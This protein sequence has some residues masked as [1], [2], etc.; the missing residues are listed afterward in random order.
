MSARPK[1]ALLWHPRHWR[2]M[3]KKYL[4]WQHV[5]LWERD[6]MDIGHFRSA[7]RAAAWADLVIV[8][9]DVSVIHPKYIDALANH[10]CV[11]N[12]GVLD[13]RKSSTSECTLQRDSTWT[14]P[15]IVKSNLNRE[16]RPERMK[17][18]AAGFKGSWWSRKESQYLEFSSLRAV[19]TWA[20]KGNSWV[21]ERQELQRTGSGYATASATFFGN[22][23]SAVTLHAPSTVVKG[24]NSTR[25]ERMKQVPEEILHKRKELLLDYGKIDF[26][27]NERGIHVFDVNKTI[28][29]IQ[30][31]HPETAGANRLTEERLRKRG[32]VIHRYLSGEIRPYQSGNT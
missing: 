13:I 1:I 10:P 4:L 24:A 8:H 20:W 19:P 3:R 21:V 14:G 15:V 32:M 7:R 17:G 26:T 22:E 28:G 30:F 11:L 9:M 16:G 25:T 31:H 29:H 2:F 27:T 18:I 5:E 12:R 6:G 23:I